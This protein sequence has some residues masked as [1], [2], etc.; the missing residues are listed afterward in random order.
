MV[1]AQQHRAFE[2]ELGDDMGSVLRCEQRAALPNERLPELALLELERTTDQL[3]REIHL[4][5]R[6]FG[7]TSTQFNALRILQ[8]GE[9]GGLTCS[10]L[11]NRLI[12][13]DPDITRLLDR[14]ARQGLVRRHRDAR[15]RRVV[16]TEITDA[17]AA[18]LQS[19]A[20]HLDTRVR[21]LF[22]HMPQQ[23]LEQLIELLEETR[24]TDRT[25]DQ[26]NVQELPESRG[27]PTSRAG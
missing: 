12:S 22:E 9:P 17:G 16:L 21:A 10:G 20:P 26:G 8:N 13:A 2:T 14:L 27:L 25:A 3:R 15:D 1:R 23:R 18:L 11:G 7:L 6:T 5:L 4:L 24:L 19:I